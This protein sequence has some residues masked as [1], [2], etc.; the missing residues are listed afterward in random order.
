MWRPSG[1]ATECLEIAY[2][3]QLR[4]VF[5]EPN[6]NFPSL[7]LRFAHLLAAAI[8]TPVEPQLLSPVDL[9]PYVQVLIFTGLL[10]CIQV[11]SVLMA[12]SPN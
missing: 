6:T 1:K 10:L 12:S 4:V 7:H 5:Y 2:L 8:N 11:I 9:T 3:Y